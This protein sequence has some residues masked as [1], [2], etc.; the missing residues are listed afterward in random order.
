MISREKIHKILTLVLEITE[1]GEGVDGYP[2]V[3]VDISNVG[4]FM[5]L[6]AMKNG[7]T[8]RGCWDISMMIDNDFEAD[9]AIKELEELLKNAVDRIEE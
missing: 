4:Y 1:R 8:S 7:F 5:N 6:Y 2:C 9:Q 3:Y